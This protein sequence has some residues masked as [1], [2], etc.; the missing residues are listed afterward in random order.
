MGM[1]AAER[2]RKYRQAMKDDEWTYKQYLEYEKKRYK[3]RKEKGETRLI[4]D[5]TRG[6]KNL[7]RRKWRKEKRER[8]KKEKEEEVERIR[9]SAVQITP[10][11]SPEDRLIEVQEGRR[12]GR[13]RVKT[14]RTKAYREIQRLKEELKKTIKTAEKC[15][16]V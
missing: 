2:M 16:K 1:S 13:R 9:S 15:R 3:R 4:D 10:P 5:C 14:N 7:R 6:E 8:R 11:Q 12:S